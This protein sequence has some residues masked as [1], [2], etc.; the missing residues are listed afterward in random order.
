LLKPS[1]AHYIARMGRPSMNFHADLFR[2]LDYGEEVDRIVAAA[3]PGAGTTRSPR[4]RTRLVDEIA[5]VGDAERV[6]AEVARR[7]AAG[8]SMLLVAVAMCPRCSPWPRPSVRRPA[9]VPRYNTFYLERMSSP[10]LWTIARE[11]PNLT[12]VVGPDGETLTY[13]RACRPGRPLRARV[14]R[15]S[16]CARVTPWR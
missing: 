8:V 11:Q 4:F 6:R 10:G 12:A 15:R 7:E 5:I 3:T 2:R 16:G 14:C 1:L 13:G 9:L